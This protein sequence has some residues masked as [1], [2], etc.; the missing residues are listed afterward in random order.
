MGTWESTGTPK[1]SE[2]DCKGQNTSHCSIFYIIGKIS[3]CRCR[4]WACMSHL[5]ICNTSYGKKKGQESNWQFD[6]RPLKS[7]ELTWPQCMQVVCNT[8]LKIFQRELQVCLRTHP[9]QRSEQRVIT[10]Q[11]GESPNRDSFRTPPWESRDKKPF[12]CRCRGKAQRI[13]YGGKWWLP[14]SPGRGESC[15]SRITRGLS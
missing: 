3:K 15:E 7:W 10:P 4:K 8:P 14:P 6:S 12:G 1:T 11:S 5:D 9:N 2:F 13:L